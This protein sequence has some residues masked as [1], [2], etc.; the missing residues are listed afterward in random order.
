MRPFFRAGFL[1][2]RSS[3]LRKLRPSESRFVKDEDGATAVEFVLLA[4]PFLAFLFALLAMGF[5]YLNATMLDDGAAQA[6][7]QIR[8]GEAEASN[9]TKQGFK[10]L[11]CEKMAIEEATCLANLIVDVTSDPDL[12]NLDTDAP[13]SDGK[14]DS[15]KETFQ[16]G[17]PSDY[18]IVKVY[19][20]MNTL[21][22]L[23][24]LIDGGESPVFTLSSVEVFRNEPYE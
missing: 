11:V 14:L 7:R 17:D 20:P 21:S 10:K 12:S 4:T 18:V 8:V 24:S 15:S 13:T 22:G 2:K 16:P 9:L 6:G 1:A 5:M 19:L 23:F 3:M